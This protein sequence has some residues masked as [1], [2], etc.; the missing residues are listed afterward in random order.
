MTRSEALAF[1]AVHGLRGRDA[2]SSLDAM[3]IRVGYGNK[4]IDRTIETARTMT[5][6]QLVTYFGMD[7]ARAARILSS[8]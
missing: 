8:H 5:F 7:G 6:P 1:L 4:T 3:L 2:Q